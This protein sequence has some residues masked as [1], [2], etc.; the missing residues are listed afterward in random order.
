M[1]IVH[2]L[3]AGLLASALLAFSA[4]SDAALVSRLGGV[5][6]YDNDLDITWL[7]DTK[8]SRSETFGLPTYQDYLG[9]SPDFIGMNGDMTF[10]IAN[11]YIAAMNAY[12]AGQGYLGVNSWRLPYAPGNDPTCVGDFHWQGLTGCVGSELGHLT[13]TEMEGD[14]GHPFGQ[15]FSEM[16]GMYWSGTLVPEDTARVLVTNLS[17]W[18]FGAQVSWEKHFDTAYVLPTAEGD[19]FATPVPAAIWFLASGLLAMV[20]IAG[21]RRTWLR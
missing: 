10:N 15:L 5:A 16:S 21:R 2:T 8:L 20:G 17:D 6:V 1:N 11:D 13:L 4:V 9:G 12:D 19:V 7:A 14:H 18:A 3:P